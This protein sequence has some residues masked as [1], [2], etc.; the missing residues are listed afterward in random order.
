MNAKQKLLKFK[1]LCSILFIGIFYCMIIQPFIDTVNSDLK[2]ITN[3][4]E[5]YQKTPLRINI[6]YSAKL[7]PNKPIKGEIYNNNI[8]GTTV[9]ILPNNLNSTILLYG[10]DKAAK[11][12]FSKHE[13]TF[14]IVGIIC[15][16]LILAASIV[17]L[18]FFIKL[19]NDFRHNIIFNKKNGRRIFVVGITLIFNGIIKNLFGGVA[20]KEEDTTEPTA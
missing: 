17:F 13:K 18:I 3:Q 12:S 6:A 20:N 5:M 11:E 14:L 4:G 8:Q 10:N 19:I 1:L 2:I 9:R 16:T 7:V 15:N